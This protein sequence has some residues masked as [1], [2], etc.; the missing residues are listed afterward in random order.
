M[1]ISL[2]P[3]EL[4]VMIFDF[5]TLNDRVDLSTPKRDNATLRSLGLVSNRFHRI[6]QPL[7]FEEISFI[8]SGDQQ[9]QVS[10]IERTRQLHALLK[11]DHEC[12]LRDIC[13][14][15]YVDIDDY[16]QDN[17]SDYQIVLDLLSWFTRLRSLVIVG[18]FFLNA[19]DSV[20]ALTL[21]TINRAK[22]LGQLRTLNLEGHMWDGRG[23]ITLAEVMKSVDSQSLDT[24]E[25]TTI[26]LSDLP[27]IQEMVDIDKLRTA[28][29]TK[30]RLIACKDDPEAI[31]ALIHWPK[32]LIN[33]TINTSGN[34]GPGMSL[35][36]MA[37]CL[38][39]HKD[40]LTTISIDLLGRPH[41]LTFDTRKFPHLDELWLSRT[42]ICEDPW[43]QEFEWDPVHADLL[44]GPSLRTFGLVF[45]V[46]G[47]TVINNWGSLEEEWIRQL[48]KVACERRAVLSTIAITFN[49][50]DP[51]PNPDVGVYRDGKYEYPWD[52]MDKLAKEIK[53]YGL[54]LYYS[55]PTW[56]KEEWL[57]LCGDQI[58]NG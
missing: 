53:E 29:F 34:W 12:K 1:S 48:A 44:L 37:A 27:A 36:D 33:F 35:Q 5:A 50:S 47:H 15:F 31:A 57:S 28:S 6:V 18:G 22:D 26:G 13:L 7:L 49:P 11:H 16:G 39:I 8:Y 56:T 24:L 38:S 41:G 20:R 17:Q 3:E 9:S 14:A 55:T 10:P 19:P 21:E 51:H 25:V 52:R 46:M 54:D 58:S 42:Q 2:L 4:L 30:L 43:G 23:G 45:G 40:T 32:Q